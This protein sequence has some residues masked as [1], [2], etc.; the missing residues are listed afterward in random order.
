MTPTVLWEECDQIIRASGFGRVNLLV[1]ADGE[2][3]AGRPR[4]HPASA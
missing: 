4:F 3:A 1:S 2:N